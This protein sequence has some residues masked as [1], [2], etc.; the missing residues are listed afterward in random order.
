MNQPDSIKG[1]TTEASKTKEEEAS[2]TTVMPPEVEAK[3]KEDEAKEAEEE[4]AEDEH[5]L[6]AHPQ[7]ERAWR[8]SETNTR[9]N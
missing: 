2:Q 7:L 5:N 4:A 8:T 9:L 3:H 1:R 6:N